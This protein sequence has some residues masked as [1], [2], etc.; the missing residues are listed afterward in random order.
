MNRSVR[1]PNLFIIGAPK[2]GT[3]SLRAWLAEHPQ[4]YMSS[5][6]E[7][8]HFNTDCSFREAPD[9]H[10]YENLF[11][12]AKPEHAAIGEATTRYLYSSEALVNILNYNSEAR[13]VAMVRN[14]VEMVVSFHGQR[15][16]NEN[17]DVGSFERAWRLQKDRANGR[18]IPPLCRAPEFL[19][20]GAVCCLGEQVRRMLDLIPRE[21]RHVVVLDDLKRNP[22]KEWNEVLRFLRIDDDG[23]TQFPVQNLAKKMR[24][25][26]VRA[27]TQRIANLKETVGLPRFRLGLLKTIHSF[28]R[29]EQPNESI[30]PHLQAELKEYFREDVGLLGELLERDFSGWL[31]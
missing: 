23:R 15:L 27:A 11:A 26:H 3:T 31:R 16:F 12:S 28:N 22:L 1:R 5:R 6:K 10:E 25:K 13:V 8:N 4:V 2:C 29:R 30:S 18:F 17:E 9:R 14:P 20:Y 7:P 21:Q 24:N 19:Q